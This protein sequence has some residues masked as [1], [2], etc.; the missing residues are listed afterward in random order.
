M[1]AAL[2]SVVVTGGVAGEAPKEKGD[3]TGAAAAGA[4]KENPPVPP[5][6]VEGN[7]GFGASILAVVLVTGGGCPNVKGLLGAESE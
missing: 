6:D 4:P 1:K 7:S 3:F 5:D 2:F